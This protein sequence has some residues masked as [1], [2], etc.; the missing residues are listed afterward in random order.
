MEISSSC[1]GNTCSITLQGDLTLPD[2]PALRTAF[3]KALLDADDIKIGMKNV[4]GADL[5]CLQLLCSLHRSGIRL[6][7]RVAINNFPKTF[8]GGVCAAG[9][10]RSSGCKLDCDKNC[11][12]V[13][14]AGETNG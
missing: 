7:K 8:R 9:F 14:I 2:A 5:S 1:S 13:E 12:W 6:K 4:K 3:I 11:L 10:V